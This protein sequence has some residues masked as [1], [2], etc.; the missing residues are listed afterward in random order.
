MLAIASTGVGLE[1]QRQVKA[2]EPS[3]ETHGISCLEISQLIQ[4]VIRFSAGLQMPGLAL[5]ENYRRQ[6]G[7]AILAFL[8]WH[9]GGCLAN[10]EKNAVT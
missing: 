3:I 2:R 7:G 4:G 5:I 9:E 6:Y 10:V 8:R 1:D